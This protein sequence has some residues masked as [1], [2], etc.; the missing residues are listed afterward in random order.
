VVRIGV[1]RGVNTWRL[2]EMLR[3][4]SCS[5]DSKERDGSEHGS[6]PDRP[7]TTTPEMPLKRQVPH[8][9]GNDD[10]ATILVT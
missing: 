4:V 7:V 2:R 6:N 1:D 8:L 3:D 9:T 5:Q 10:C